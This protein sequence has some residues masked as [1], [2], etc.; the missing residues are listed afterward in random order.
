MTGAE[1]L[2]CL[3]VSTPSTENGIDYVIAQCTET[4]ADLKIEQD[5]V[6]QM[7][8]H[9]LRGQ[10]NENVSRLIKTPGTQWTQSDLQSVLGTTS[11]VMSREAASDWEC[12]DG[13]AD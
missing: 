5:A 4:M 2:L 3:L 6:P 12:N 10:K 7:L 13:R 1:L 9:L 11:F 8:Q